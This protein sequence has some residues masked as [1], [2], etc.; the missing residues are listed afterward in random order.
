[1]FTYLDLQYFKCFEIL[2]LPL[3]PL[4]L[5]AGANGSGKSS[6]L[7]ALA[8][9]HQTMHRRN[10]SGAIELN[11]NVVRLGSATDVI[12]Q[13]RGQGFF[14]IRLLDAETE[15]LWK[16]VPTNSDDSFMIKSIIIDGNDFER[17]LQSVPI[18]SLFPKL[19][20]ETEKRHEDFMQRIRRL[21]YLDSQR[22]GSYA[23]Y[24]TLN[25]DFTPVFG[26]RRKHGANVLIFPI[27]KPVM[28]NLSLPNAERFC[29]KQVEARM[30]QFFPEFNLELC[31][32]MSS[33]SIEIG[34]RSSLN[35]SRLQPINVGSG[36]MQV[37]PIVV[38]ALCTRPRDVILIEYPEMLLHASGQALMGM[39]LAEV[40][41]AGVQVLVETHSDHILNGI[42]RAVKDGILS[43]GETRLHF[44]RPRTTLATDLIPQV[45]S[46]L[47]DPNGNIDVWPEGFFDQIDRDMN[48]FA[49]WDSC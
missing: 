25:A 35:K 33:K 26:R 18:Q 28:E 4:T 21:S 49:G 45:E 10:Y 9:L 43:A 3:R 14:T 42:R 15:Y 39:F 48:Y 7:H 19:N 27:N 13:V 34:L 38:S 31:P 2:K 24:P 6:V 47:M 22:I 16:F 32:I 11:G 8:L 12:D 20:A 29:L 36:M 44:F 17:Q 40:A 37:L 1:M 46:P 23:V 41:S 30:N 5:L